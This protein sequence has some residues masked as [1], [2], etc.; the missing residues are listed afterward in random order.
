MRKMQFSDINLKNPFYNEKIKLKNGS[1]GRP[2]KFTA[3][4]FYNDK[5]DMVEEPS[6]FLRPPVHV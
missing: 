5:L 4:F 6:T 1:D 3:Y 2:G